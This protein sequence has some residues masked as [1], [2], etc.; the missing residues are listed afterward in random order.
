[1]EVGKA[2]V[3]RAAAAETGLRKELA[4]ALADATRLEGESRALR[5][6]AAAATAAAVEAA[7][8]AAV[9][10]AAEEH[11]AAAE[12]ARQRYEESEAARAVEKE[13][14]DTAE[15]DSVRWCGLK[16]VEPRV[17][18]VEAPGLSA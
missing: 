1:V 7:R 13:R 12:R 16:P 11:A 18:S 3:S 4:A 9:A 6:E 15:C 8:A 10:A 2:G 14:A 5:V 17:V